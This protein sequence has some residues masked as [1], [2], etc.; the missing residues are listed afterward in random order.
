[1]K[2]FCASVN[3]DAFMRFRSSPNQGNLAENSSFIRSSF[4]GTEHHT[5]LPLMRIHDL[6]LHADCPKLI[7]HPMKTHHSWRQ[8]NLHRAFAPDVR[9]AICAP[10]TKQLIS[11]ALEPC[12]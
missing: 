3:F 6:R 1:M 4:Q 7:H 12:G 9:P 5:D 11:F 2:A 10:L 8:C